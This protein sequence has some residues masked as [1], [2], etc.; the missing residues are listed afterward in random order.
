MSDSETK[1]IKNQKQPEKIK[2]HI[3]AEEHYPKVAPL[4]K[5]QVLF[6][7]TLHKEHHNQ[8]HPYQSHY[9]LELIHFQ[10]S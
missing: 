10:E 1:Q 2:K 5:V 7:Q 8:D 6:T 9:S 3:S 4:Q